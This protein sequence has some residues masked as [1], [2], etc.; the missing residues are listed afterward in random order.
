MVAHYGIWLLV[1]RSMELVMAI[2]LA[3]LISSR[4]ITIGVLLAWSFAIGPIVASIGF[5]GVFRELVSSA[6]VDAL[7]PVIG[8]DNPL[9][10]MS[11]GA[12]I[13]VV[14]L[15]CAVFLALGAWRTNTQDA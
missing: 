4:G 12:A 5:L 7:R 8:D 2:G 10:G 3:S 1:A 9:V 6:A 11:I 13:L 14:A 15:Y